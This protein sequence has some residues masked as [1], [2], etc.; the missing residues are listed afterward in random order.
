MIAQKRSS[1]FRLSADAFHGKGGLSRIRPLMATGDWAVMESPGPGL[2]PANITGT[3][4]KR[5][6][7]AR[8][9]RI[10]I[11]PGQPASGSRKK[12]S[13]NGP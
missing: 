6:R 4:D 9:E 5:V 7:S 2:I 8:R 10:F 1:K 12:P 11:G 13:R 3:N